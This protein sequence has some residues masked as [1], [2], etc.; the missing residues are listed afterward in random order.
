M[1]VY[2]DLKNYE[3]LPRFISYWYQIDTIRKLKPKSILEVGKGTGFVYDYLKKSGFNIIS[4]DF[5]KALKPDILLDVRDISSL[6]KKFDLMSCSEVIEHMPYEDAVICL[7]KF[8]LMSKYVLL[9]IPIAGNYFSVN[10]RFSGIK[11]LFKRELISIPFVVK[12]F[13]KNFIRDEEH[14]WELGYKDYP[15]GKFR[16]I[17]RSN[18]VIE[19][20]FGNGIYPYHKFF[21]LRSKMIK[22]LGGEDVK[23][24]A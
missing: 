13:W 6:N 2:K 19:K 10:I 3:Q 7:S 4:L 11:R 23:S 9:C 12:P 18:F 15:I 1:N 24:N 8:S 17:L 14:H 20:E 22:I 16:K 21:L 5:D